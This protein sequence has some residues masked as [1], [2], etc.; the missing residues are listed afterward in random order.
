MTP[1]AASP[2][3]GRQV[4][5]VGALVWLLVEILRGWTPLLITVFGRA[6]ET[7]PELIGLFVLVVTGLP[8]VVL[9]LAADRL[10][11]GAAVPALVLAALVT[12]L[13]MPLSGAG[14]FSSSRASGWSSRCSP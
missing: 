11:S 3:A 9:A 14:S 1:S 8:L 13:V 5:A 10:A 2:P 12:R 6:A 4:W 7:P